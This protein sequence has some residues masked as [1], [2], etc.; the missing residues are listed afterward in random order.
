MN[1]LPAGKYGQTGSPALF[2][3]Q[4]GLNYEAQAETDVNSQRSDN[5]GRAAALADK[6]AVGEAMQLLE[7]AARDGDAEAAAMLGDWRLSGARIRRD[8]GLARHWYGR[9]AELGMEEIEP[10]YIALLA[11]GAG[12]IERRWSDAL[13]RL[14]GLAGHD[15][16]AARQR[17]LIA[18]MQ[19]TPEGDPVALGR[20]ETLGKRPAMYCYKNFMTAEECRYLV[21][22]CATM[23]QP[24]TVVHPVSGALVR[25]PIRTARTASFPF[26]REDPVLHAINRRIAAATA[27]AY[28]QGEPLQILC[29]APGEEYKMHSDTL[30]PGHNQRDDTFLVALSQDYEGGET[31][32]PEAGI[33]WRGSIGD[34]LHFRSVD[35][36]GAPDPLARHCGQPVTQGVKY[37]L[38][39]WIRREPLDIS[40]PPGRPF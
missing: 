10:T 19:L 2:V 13:A 18:Q 15:L 23:L 29:Y 11:N 5:I 7:D 37:M 1:I 39:K 25:D 8:L 24:A 17:G 27:T 36:T 22:L 6:G 34:A 20:A 4:A 3:A 31:S 21:D 9:A 26:V 28:A 30:P 40:G 16:W 32:F 33:G 38:S 14:D 35:E 12:G